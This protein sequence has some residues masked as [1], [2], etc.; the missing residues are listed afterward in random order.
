MW[1]RWCEIALGA[2]LAV[3][4]FWFDTGDD[5]TR[6]INPWLCSIL[7]IGSASLSFFQSFWW[8]HW[9]NLIVALWLIL[10]AFVA[11]PY[12]T[13]PDLLNALYVGGLLLMFAIVPNEASMPPPTWRESLTQ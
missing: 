4:S 6:T 8:G 11:E 10:F 12:P 3:S 9:L 5:V 7:I 2:W 1:G 13:P